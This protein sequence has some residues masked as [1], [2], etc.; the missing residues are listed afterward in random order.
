M[1]DP[2]LQ[3]LADNIIN[4]SVALKAG[5]KILIDSSGEATTTLVKN[6]I[7]T[8]ARAGGV[9]VWQRMDETYMRQLLLHGTESQ[10]CDFSQIHLQQMKTYQAYVAVRG[11]N[12]IFELNDVPD[13]H[14]A[15]YMKYYVGEVGTQR[16]KHTRWCVLR[17]PNA[18]MAQLAETSIDDFTDFYFRTTLV[19]YPKLARAMAPLA[20]LMHRTDR[21]RVTAK[22]TDL[23]LSIQGI[24]AIPCDGK[25]NIPDGEVFTAPVRDSVNGTI[26]YNASGPYL[27][28]MFPNVRLTFRDG[29]IVEATCDGDN[30]ALNRIFDTDAGARY[31]G[32]FAIGFHPWIRKPMRDILFDEKIAGSLHMA[33]GRC[34]DEA[35][36]GNTDSAIHWDLVLIQR[37]DYGGG[38]I[39]FDDRLIRK[40]GRFV[41]P[42]LVGLNPEAFGAPAI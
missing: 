27:G 37:P 11:T 5:E 4:Y 32:E 1:T 31:V 10:F 34:Y 9:P 17:Y 38:E 23:T 22:G 36:N 13:E 21:V 3:Q 15:W 14:R 18:S 39:Y 42:E 7:A 33:M 25:F 28:Q 40:D 8:A 16:V 26:C 30:A 29:K 24:P 41:V 12:N 35:S 2:R 19:D 6:L 20:E